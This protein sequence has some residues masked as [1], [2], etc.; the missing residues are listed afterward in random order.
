MDTR[1]VAIVV[2]L[3]ALAFS[4]L[5][6]AGFQPSPPHWAERTVSLLFGGLAGLL[7]G[8]TSIPGPLFAIYLSTLGLE[9]RAFVYGI[10]LLLLAANVFQVLTYLRLDLFAGGLLVASA[11]LAPALLLGQQIGSRIQN[12]LDPVRF[13]RVVLAVVALSGANLLARGLGLL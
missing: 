5:S 9:K 2:G 8:W 13:T 7:N 12:R 4:A 10:T 3:V 11:A 6:F 1:A